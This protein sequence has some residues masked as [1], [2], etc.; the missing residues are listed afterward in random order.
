M[1]DLLI[2]AFPNE[3]SARAAGGKFRSLEREGLFAIRDAVIAVRG[4]AG[5]I[6][7]VA[8][9]AASD[10]WDVR[11]AAS[12]YALPAATGPLTDYGA[13]DSFIKDVAEALAPGGVAVFVLADR[14]KSDDVL[15]ALDDLGGTAVHTAFDKSATAAI[16]AALAIPPA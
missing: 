2:V 4:A 16:R 12:G 9:S 13:S 10:F 7:L 11:A 15:D 1:S 3:Q 14:I 8:P 6:R 5:D